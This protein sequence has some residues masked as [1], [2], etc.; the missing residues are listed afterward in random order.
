M[1]ILYAGSTNIIL[2]HTKHDNNL[3]I[4]DESHA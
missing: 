3:R 4:T 2:G 1:T